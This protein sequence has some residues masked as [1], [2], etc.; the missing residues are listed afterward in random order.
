MQHTKALFLFSLLHCSAA[1]RWSNSDVPKI[2]FTVEAANGTSQHEAARILC[3]PLTWPSLATFLLG[4]FA[5]HIATVQSTPGEKWQLTTFN[6]ILALFFPTSGL[7]RGMN[8]LVRNFSSSSLCRNVVAKILRVERWLQEETGL[9]KACK[10]GAL[11]MVVRNS[12]WRPRPGG[13]SIPARLSTMNKE[14]IDKSLGLELR[15]MGLNTAR[16]GMTLDEGQNDGTEAD[17]E[18]N[19]VSGSSLEMHP[20]GKI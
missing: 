8:A 5:A 20:Q 4:N 10:A 6:M 2:D 7:M 13:N 1:I 15:L 17:L 9:D 19:I 11:C 3:Y 18:E 12:N 14:A 16:N